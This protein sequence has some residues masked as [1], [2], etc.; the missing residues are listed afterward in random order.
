[1][2]PVFLRH[3]KGAR[4]W[5]VALA[6]VI[7]AVVTMLAFS[8]ARH[9]DEAAIVG[10][11]F[12]IPE[13]ELK[14]L[15]AA[16]EAG[17]PDAQSRLAH[18]I[19]RFQGPGIRAF[20]LIRR[21][22]D[23]QHPYSE[24]EMGMMLSGEILVWERDE[25]EIAKLGAPVPNDVTWIKGPGGEGSSLAMD[26]GKAVQWFEKSAAQGVYQAWR[27]LAVAYKDG[28]GVEPDPIQSTKWVRKL[29]EAGDPGYMLDYARR[30][31][32]G[33]G[34]EPD[35][36]K[37]FAWSLFVI[38]STY[39]AKSAIGSKARAI[40]KRLESKLTTD[41]IQAARS[42]AKELAKHASVCVGGLERCR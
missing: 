6:S 4:A 32:D 20:Q 12:P 16:A 27:E 41:E 34:V 28:R 9:H 36:I 10:L 33:E 26:H 3:L 40:G 2:N 25:S 35:S 17:D 23:Q 19:S 18:E 38:E 22:A 39:P 14:A 1:M 11:S 15:E 37:A 30:L 8:D 13:S 7:A 31:E 5:L 42:Y 29:A 24:Y 21:A